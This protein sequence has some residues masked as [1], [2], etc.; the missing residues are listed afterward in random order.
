MRKLILLSLLM[1]SFVA[2]RNA[3]SGN[4]QIENVQSEDYSWVVDESSYNKAND[5]SY[6]IYLEAVTAA[7]KEC[8]AANLKAY[9]EWEEAGNQAYE[10]AMDACDK[11][12]DTYLDKLVVIENKLKALDAKSFSLYLEKRNNPSSTAQEVNEY[13][14]QTPAARMFCSELLKIDAEENLSYQKIEAE[15]AAKNALAEKDK[16][17]KNAKAEAVKM[18][19]Y[20][21][22]E[23]IK[24]ERWYKIFI[25]YNS[26]KDKKLN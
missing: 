10:V 20:K 21:L 15:K 6:N 11:V 7:S 9:E 24:Q 16:A 5:D 18:A 23:D 17:G 4:D 2:C 8:E 14:P 26:N 12:F 3:K 19:K 22:A 25:S 1:I 13:L